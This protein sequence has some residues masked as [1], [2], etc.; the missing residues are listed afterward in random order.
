MCIR[1]R[2]P[3]VKHQIIGCRPGEKLHEQL[4]SK[5]DAPFTYEFENY[6]KILPAIHDWSK[7]PNRIKNGKLVDPEFN[8]SSENNKEWMTIDYLRQ[9]IKENIEFDLK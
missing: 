5:E 7:D 2:D 9:W 1:D 6:F 8:Y 4:I 3:Q